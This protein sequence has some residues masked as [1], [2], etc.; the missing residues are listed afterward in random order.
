MSSDFLK[1]VVETILPTYR[2][3]PMDDEKFYPTKIKTISSKVLTESIESKMIGEKSIE[4]W[5]DNPYEFELL[6]MDI[7]D[8][9]KIKCFESYQMTRYKIIVIV[10]VGQKKDQGVM[11]SS[12]CLW[13]ASTDNYVTVSYENQ[14]IWSTAIVFGLYVD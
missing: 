9:I 13:D 4:L 7:A 3:K 5:F 11:I 8:T 14:L 10:T 12:R 6:A 1:T 2:L